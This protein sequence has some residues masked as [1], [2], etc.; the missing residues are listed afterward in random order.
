MQQKLVKLSVGDLSG[1]F[2]F[3]VMSWAWTITGFFNIYI[4]YIS[5]WP[6]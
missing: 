6:I 1:N 5:F 2:F 4:V 3:F